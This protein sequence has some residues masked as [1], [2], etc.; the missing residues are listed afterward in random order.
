MKNKSFFSK[1]NSARL[2]AIIFSI[3]AGV[4]G[5]THGIGELLQG[6][7]STKGIFILSWAQGPIATNMGGDPA[8]TIVPNFLITGILA[9]LF[10]LVIILG[11]FVFIKKKNGGLILIILS[12][13]MLLFGG[14]FAP[15]VVGILAGVSG[16]G[17]N[18]NHKWYRKY[19]PNQIQRLFSK[20]WNVIFIICLIDGIFL[21]FGSVIL[22]G[23]FN[24]N[25]PDLF[26]KSF[27][28]L[29]PLLLLTIFTGIAYD[30]QNKSKKPQRTRT[31]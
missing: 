3:L 11:S 30:L 12:I 15:V 17:I 19:I 1:I 27:L 6:N 18:S 5:I 8:M 14:G 4:G 24:L 23:I 29:I 25:Q 7:S 16:L 2:V 28:F 9:I 21:T 20:L 10:S 13:F 22:V 31:P 26:V